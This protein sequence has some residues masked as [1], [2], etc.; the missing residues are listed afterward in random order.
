MV[1]KRL[2]KS[3]KEVDNYAPFSGTNLDVRY[4][5]LRGIWSVIIPFV[6]SMG[7]SM[8]MAHSM[9]MS[10]SAGTFLGIAGITYVYHIIP[11]GVVAL[12]SKRLL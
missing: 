7:S 2:R 4:Y 8:S 5:R 6:G 9:S 10:S 1:L 12:L 3:I 11:G